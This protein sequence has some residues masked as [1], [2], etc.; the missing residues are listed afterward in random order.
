[1]GINTCCWLLPLL[2]ECGGRSQ[3]EGKSTQ[4]VVD[5]FILPKTA[6]SK[7][8]MCEQML[9]SGSLMVGKPTLFGNQ[10]R[11]VLTLTLC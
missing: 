11:Y 4:N 3:F 6:V 1:M 7:V 2:E 8:S 10:Y 9:E 5:D